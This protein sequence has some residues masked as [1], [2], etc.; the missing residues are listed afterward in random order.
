[1]RSKSSQFVGSKAVNVNHESYQSL[2]FRFKRWHWV[3]FI[4]LLGVFFVVQYI[5]FTDLQFFDPSIESSV[6]EDL[7]SHDELSR[8]IVTGT[9]YRQA[10]FIL[11]GLFGFA[12]L[13]CRKVLPLGV[14]GKLGWIIPI[15]MTWVCLSV[16]WAEDITLTFR[17][18]IIFIL[19]CLGVVAV[20]RR[21][22]FED[23]V[24]FSF[25]STF[26]YMLLGIAVEI[27]RGG[28]HPLTSEYRF[29]GTFHPNGQ[30]MNCSLL[31]LTAIYLAGKDRRGTIWYHA[32]ALT[33][34][35]F[36][37]LTKSRAS[38]ASV[39]C[40]ILIYCFLVLSG[41]QKGNCYSLLHGAVRSSFFFTVIQL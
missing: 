12:T 35:I 1:M 19:F 28:F 24:R 20:V 8:S 32:A 36:L 17:R 6:A 34:F 23:M 27:V 15:Y 16:T 3:F 9:L 10:A 41:S 4:L 38:L 40:A 11:L 31:L 13:F 30:G 26:I 22:R 2:S 18:E 14:N 33:A 37:F 39:I 25:F 21:F 5:P 29:A 7:M